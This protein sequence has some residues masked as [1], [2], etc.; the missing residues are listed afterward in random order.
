[1]VDYERALAL[2]VY[3]SLSGD[4]AKEAVYAHVRPALANAPD[5]K[6]KAKE[7]SGLQGKLDRLRREAHDAELD[8]ARAEIERRAAAFEAEDAARNAA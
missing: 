5:A 1:V 7:V 4:G 8:E 3:V 6:T 2:A